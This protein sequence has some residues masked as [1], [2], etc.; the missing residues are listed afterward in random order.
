[1]NVLF[2]SIAFPPKNDPECIQTA[3]YFKYL[4]REPDLSFDVV[5]SSIP[6]LFMPVDETLSG[7]DTGYQTKIEIPVY[8]G[9]LTNF[10]M[11]KTG[12]GKLMFPE[13]KMTFHWQWKKVVR[14]MN[15]R[16]DLIYSR[17][18]PMSS[19]FMALKLKRYYKVPWV[20]HLSDPWALSPLER[21][22]QREASAEAMLIAE[23]DHITFTTKET[24]QRYADHY[25]EHAHKFGVIPNVYDPDEVRVPVTPVGE[26][27]RIVYTGGLAGQRS[28]FFLNQVLQQIQD[29]D[30]TL[31]DKIAIEV[32]GPMDR[33]NA[34]FFKNTP[35]GCISHRG[36]L[37]YEE[38]KRLQDSAHILLVVDNPTNTAGAVFFP[39]KLLDYFLTGKMIMACTPAGSV[40]R[41]ILQDY[42]P[43]V[44][45]AQ[46]ETEAMAD[47]LLSQIKK[48]SDPP[49]RA[50]QVELP[51]KYS[52]KENAMLLAALFRRIAVTA[53]RVFS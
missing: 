51:V 19:A 49:D 35:F 24:V 40:T 47:F 34:D 29:R 10:I 17:S 48:I 44:C 36:I 11:R 15:K 37:T 23:A 7:L 21:S 38:A 5:T 31:L 25:P 46:T 42:G 12:L 8:E 28:L 3:R 6:T 30:K 18:N 53:D 26:K 45:F 2:V 4:K 13:S 50:S 27:L 22:G 52:A 9:K 39:S 33:Y 20:M 1:M 14:A 32:A 16:P 43:S 41:N